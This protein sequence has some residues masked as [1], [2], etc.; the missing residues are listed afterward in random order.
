[1][2]K[3]ARSLAASRLGTTQ[4]SEHGGQ[5]SPRPDLAVEQ[6]GGGRFHQ[7]YSSSVVVDEQVRAL[8]KV[9]C[10]YEVYIVMCSTCSV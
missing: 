10:G 9:E 1:M 2:P 8:G 5:R 4:Q 7:Q 6:T 3:S